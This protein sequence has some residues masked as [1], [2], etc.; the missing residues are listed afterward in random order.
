MKDD[1]IRMCHDMIPDHHLAL[2]CAQLAVKEWHE[3]LPVGVDIIPAQGHVPL[4]GIAFITAKKWA[5]GR[6]LRIAF[7]DGADYYT[8][9]VRRV[10]SQWLQY[11]N[12]GFDFVSNPAQ[13]EVRISFSLAGA[14]SFIGT[15]NLGIDPSRPTMN[16]GFISEG[17]ILHEFGHLL[18]CI[19][20]HQHPEADIPWDKPEV[21]TY[22]QGPPN[23]WDQQTVN[24]N[25]FQKYSREITQFGKYDTKSI[26]HY[27]IDGQLLTDPSRATGWNEALSQADIDYVKRV[28]PR[29]VTPGRAVTVAPGVEPRPHVH[30][31]APGGGTGTGPVGPVQH[32]VP[33]GGSYTIIDYQGRKAIVLG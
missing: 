29:D 13:A 11:V 32:I 25:L 2:K 21:Y 31:P 24:V 20:E 10:A 5:P 33:G 3:N 1:A 9:M 18:G 28:Y 15:D 30:P 26:M 16:F 6:T 19:H 27:A 22:Y 8:H 7:L 14:W 23:N 12:L 17:T 4:P